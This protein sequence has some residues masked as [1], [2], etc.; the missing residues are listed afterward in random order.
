MVTLA[1]LDIS[2]EVLF[3]QNQPVKLVFERGDSLDYRS[4]LWEGN[5]GTHRLII[6]EA[7][8]TSSRHG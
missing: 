6:S 7:T 8:E 2:S 4:M 1:H 3:V 5:G